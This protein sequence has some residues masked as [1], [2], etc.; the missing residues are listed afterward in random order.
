LRVCVFSNLF[1]NAY[2]YIYIYHTNTH[3]AGSIK[4]MIIAV[5]S[6]SMNVHSY[7]VYFLNYKAVYALS[8]WKNVNYRIM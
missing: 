1:T 8:V 5:T 3:T 4:T 6:Y 7:A 2:I